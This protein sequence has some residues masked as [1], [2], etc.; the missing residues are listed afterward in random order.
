MLAALLD[1]QQ[2]VVEVFV[3]HRV[4]RLELLAAHAVLW[5]QPKTHRFAVNI[6]DLAH[7]PSQ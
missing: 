2:E 7:I 5:V 1:F 4:V 6:H 3:L